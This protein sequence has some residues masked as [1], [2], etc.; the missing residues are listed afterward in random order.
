MQ[1]R[2]CTLQITAFRQER[3]GLAAPDWV[4]KLIF[5][6]WAS[7]RAPIHVSR[8]QRT[9][10]LVYVKQKS[11]S[12]FRAQTRKK[13]S[14][15]TTK[16]THVILTVVLFNWPIYCRGDMSVLLF[17]MQTPLTNADIGGGGVNVFGEVRSVQAI[18]Q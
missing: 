11:K 14:T 13:V 16:D 17:S 4:H 10:T 3:Q 5:T 18:V 12:A 2:V 1:L 15:L 8:T 7:P 9:C 6:S